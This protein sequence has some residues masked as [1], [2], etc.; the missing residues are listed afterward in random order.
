MR[1]RVEPG[2]QTL[3]YTVTSP[4]AC[5][6]YKGLLGHVRR[7]G[8]DPI[9]LSSP[10][11]NLV[12]LSAMERVRSIAVSMER[13]IV[14]LDDL[15]SFWSLYRIIR[16]VRPMIVDASTPKA[17]LLT[18]IA[19]W[20]ARVPCRVYTLRGL[21][22]ETA[23]GLKRTVLW[24]AE[25]V[26]CACAHRVVC[27]SPSL[28]ARAIDLN[29]VRPEKATVLVRGGGG[30]DAMRFSAVDRNSLETDNL[31]SRLGIP[32]GALVVGFVGR[33][34]KDKGIRQLVETFQQLR[35]TYP[36][37]RL[38]LVGDF[39]HGDPVEPE[40]RGYIESETAIIRPGFVSDTAPY[41]PLMDVLALP[42]Y[43]EGLPGVPLEAQASG[44]PVVTTTATGAVD[45]IIDGATG[46]L[47]PIGDTNAL[48]NAVGK[49]LADPEL[50]ARMGG[51]GRARVERDFRP[52]AI[53]DAQV[54]FYRNLMEEKL[55]PSQAIFMKRISGGKR[56]FDVV[57]ATG[58]L[59]L[60]SP[61]L[62]AVATVIRLR[63]GSP[64]LFRQERAGWHGSRFE[65][66]KFRTMT[67]AR[68]A[69]GQLLP[70]ADRLTRLGRFLRSASLDE[71]PELVN[72]IRGEMSLVGP[73]PLLAEYLDRYSPGQMRRHEV[74]P[75][76]T[77][78]AQING[79]NALSWDRRFE[80]DLWYVDH[81]SFWLDLS[82]LAKTVWQVMRREGVAR[83][84]HATMPEFLGMSA[85]RDRGNIL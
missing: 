42:T 28:R 3:L 59:L 64:V 6:F 43:R 71:M 83:P 58:A 65:C 46:F 1:S 32:P 78:W 53:W 69:N 84:G 4:L 67:E 51:A 27:V 8:F 62:A 66:L 9:L 39:E 54:Q 55:G 26:A 37:L 10:G 25:W 76:I 72:V 75:G 11:G 85:E 14:P 35:A 41:Y 38:L 77:G 19:A 63:L 18:C 44:V 15:V 17:G 20:L 70:D 81:W 16:Q 82:I 5:S 30:V 57:L 31:R 36:Q 23:K 79:R 60:L 7:A 48:T 22:L 21:R 52:E 50:R 12:E 61:L 47:V 49:L 24:G 68:D 40:V 13:E 80:L 29:L 45:S 74:R 33:F 34:V 73:R 2:R 56:I